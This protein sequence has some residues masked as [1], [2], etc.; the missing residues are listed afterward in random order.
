MSEGRTHRRLKEQI[1][2]ALQA[3]AGVTDVEIEH[4]FG[5]V[6]ADVS[7]SLGN[8]CGAV[9]VQLSDKPRAEIDYRTRCYHGLGV[10]VIWVLHDKRTLC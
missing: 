1:A 5:P 4:H 10:Y 2:Q 3:T 7:F 6:Q 8:K 9:E